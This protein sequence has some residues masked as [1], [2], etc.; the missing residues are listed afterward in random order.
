MDTTNFYIA[1]YQRETDEVSF[2][3]AVEGGQRVR[4]QSR[5]AGQ[6]L[7]EYLLRTGKALLIQGDL[8]NRL[9]ALGVARIG[10]T[11]AS[12]LGVP[13]MAGGE[14]LGA[15]ALQSYTDSNAYD[16]GHLR[17]LST[18]ASQAAVALE[19]ARL[20]QEAQRRVAQLG[21]LQEVGLKLAA[22]TDLAAVLDAVAEA[23]LG[24][25]QANDVLI[26]L[27]D[28]ARQSFTLGTGLRDTGERGLFAPM[29]RENGLTATVAR[30]GQL[31]AIED[32][33]TH[34]LYA[35]RPAPER[36]LESIVGVPLLHSG[37]VLGVLNVSYHTHHRFAPDELRLLQ[38]LADQ[39]A[40]AVGNALLFQKMQAIMQEL[41]ETAATQSE[42]LNLVQ[43]L[44]TPVVP[45]LPGVLLVPLVGSIDSERGRQILERLLQ[46]VERRGARIVL[47]DITGVPVVDTAVAQMLLQAVQATQLL[48]GEAVLVG[49]RPEVAQTLVGLGVDLSGMTTRS[50]LQGGVAYALRQI[51]RQRPGSAR[52]G[53]WTGS[54]PRG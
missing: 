17:I 31:L 3:L 54:P 10:A 27:Y 11:A 2:P 41:Q 5:R 40:V 43:E 16:E 25:L 46:E 39:A 12:W 35:D 23:A 38:T 13:I 51:G 47:V 30:S 18:I 22:T 33:S 53:T 44:S 49:I 48:G 26:F 36:D 21:A 50:D 15:I 19:N 9:D 8:D 32:V 4:W 7:T 34:P 42:L 20:Y 1:L 29:P 6:G 37:Q 24:L 52:G 28:A 14:A 45:I